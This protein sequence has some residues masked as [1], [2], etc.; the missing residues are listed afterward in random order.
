MIL[1]FLIMGLLNEA[2]FKRSQGYVVNVEAVM[3]LIFTPGDRRD[4]GTYKI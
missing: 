3:S 1:F 4:Y 2:S